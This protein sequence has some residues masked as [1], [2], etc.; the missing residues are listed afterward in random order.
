MMSA[1]SPSCSTEPNWLSSLIYGTERGRRI[2]AQV[3]LGADEACRR[4]A[5][6]EKREGARDG[7]AG[8]QSNTA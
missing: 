8:L 5:D 4:E 6:F 2:I 1:L 3:W 7:F